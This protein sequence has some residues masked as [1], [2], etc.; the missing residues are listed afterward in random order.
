MN[1]I[2][3]LV[4]KWRE[5]CADDECTLYTMGRRSS[6]LA[7]ADELEALQSLAPAAL[8]AQTGEAVAQYRHKSASDWYDGVLPSNADQNEEFETRI[9]Y[10]HPPAADFQACV[11][12]L[13]KAHEFV[14]KFTSGNSVPRDVKFIAAQCGPTIAQDATYLRDRYILPALASVA[15]K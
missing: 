10:T 11:E 15:G 6:R 3:E 14:A 12:A 13:R 8:S 1:R 4:A 5:P 2:D 7:C 9:L